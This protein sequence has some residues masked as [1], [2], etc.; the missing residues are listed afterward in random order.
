M[1]VPRPLDVIRKDGMLLPKQRWLFDRLFEE[2]KE[3]I[4]EIHEPRSTKSHNRFRG[5]A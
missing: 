5:R 3:Y 1:I 4:I 2:G